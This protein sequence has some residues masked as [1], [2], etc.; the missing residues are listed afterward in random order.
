M[1]GMTFID[2][3]DRYGITQLVFNEAH[4]GEALVSEAE[5]LGREYVIQITGEVTERENKNPKLP[6]GGILRS[7]SRRCAY[8]I[9]QR[10]LPSLS[11]TIP[12][13]GTTCV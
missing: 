4:V 10:C 8:S 13:V 1:G 7:R 12:M 2:L 11:K 6:Y 5:K 3:R 9:L